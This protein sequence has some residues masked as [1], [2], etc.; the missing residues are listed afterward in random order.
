MPM[1]LPDAVFL[2]P[3]EGHADLVQFRYGFTLEGKALDGVKQAVVTETEDGDL[4]I[5]GYAA[6]FEGVDRQ[7]ENFEEGAFARGIKSFLGST[8]P[9]CFHHKRDVV[10]GKVLQLEEVEGKGLHMQGRVDGALRDDPSLKTIYHQIRRGTINGLSIGGFFRRRLTAAGRK[11]VDMDF[12]EISVTP[13]PVHP[14]TSFG[15]VAGKALVSDIEVPDKVTV[16][17][18]LET[19]EIR[20]DDLMWMNEALGSIER[21]LERIEK[22]KITTISSGQ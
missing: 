20:D 2:A 14:G 15:V 17:L 13:T 3:V 21:I 12:V 6:V 5:D 10:L 18:P 19:E 4:I 16:D 1:E 11:I 9:L 22:R 8:S 7:G